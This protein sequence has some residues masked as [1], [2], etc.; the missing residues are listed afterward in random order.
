MDSGDDDEDYYGYL[1]FPES[2]QDLNT[3]LLSHGTEHDGRMIMEIQHRIYSFLEN[4]T[5]N[6][7][8]TGSYRRNNE[9]NPRNWK[10]AAP[11][12]L[13]QDP[14]QE[15]ALEQYLSSARNRLPYTSVLEK[16]YEHI[17]AICG[18]RMRLSENL[19][20]GLKE[21]PNTFL[22]FLTDIREHSGQMILSSQ[23]HQRHPW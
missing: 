8:A 11:T 17:V 16:A 14:N 18:Y 5:T 2:E 15:A 1:Y 12:G 6:I 13:P 9:E 22:E 10:P 4:V 7:M 19:L 3:L 21:N 20:Q 23:S